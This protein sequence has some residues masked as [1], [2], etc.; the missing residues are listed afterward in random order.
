[1]KRINLS[2]SK[3]GSIDRAIKDLEKYKQNLHRKSELLVSRLMD[4]GIETAMAHSGQYAGM[5]TFTKKLSQAISGYDGVLIATDGQKLIKEWYASKKDGLA[6]KNVRSYEVSPLL[7]AEFGSG[8]LANVLDD[9]PGVG[10]GTMPNSMGHATD[11]DGWYWYDEN[12]VKHHSIG[13]T[14][15][16]PMHSASTA[17]LSQVD[18]IAREVFNNG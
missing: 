17:M 18:R 5:I 3:K 14:P 10:Q 7:L 4:V 9:V 11:P 8:W 6:K 16:Y 12:G 13:E 1:M 2:I 15:T